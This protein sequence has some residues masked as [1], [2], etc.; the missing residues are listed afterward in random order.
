MS[1][2]RRHARSEPLDCVVRV[3]TPERITLV[4][5]LAGP[6][7]RFVAFLL[8]Q[9][10]LM[11][12]ILAAIALILVLSM[13]SRAG[14]GPILLA[15]FVLT[16]SY[17][18]FCEGVFD[19]QTFGKYA[20][21]IRV[22]SENGV[23]ITASQAVLRNLVGVV[24]GLVPFC[25]LVGLSSMIVSRRFQRVGDL[26]A[27][28]IVMIEDRPISRPIARVS[29]REVDA[30]LE[31]LPRRVAAGPKLAR[32]VSDYVDQRRRFTPPRRAE[33]AEYL[34]RPLRERYAIRGN[35]PA[36]VVLCAFYHRL[37]LGD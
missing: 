36:D 4:L 11:A 35:V 18:A 14:L 26:A 25:F 28:T 7:R 33:M 5:P 10:L 19:G 29:S 31:W 22:V 24:D 30:L 21:G 8:D 3:V 20:L 13:G 1:L 23:A 6:A 2:V 34:A 27:G 12:L 37:F 17:G 15:Y 9:M 32:V 16:W